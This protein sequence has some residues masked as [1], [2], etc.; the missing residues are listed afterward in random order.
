MDISFIPG[1]LTYQKVPLNHLMLCHTKA[2]VFVQPCEH[3]G[4][5]CGGKMRDKYG[6]FL[7]IVRLIT[8]VNICGREAVLA[9]EEG[10]VIGLEKAR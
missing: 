5:D 3:I 6:T 9:A 10:H 8:L 2:V 7:L 4:N 1:S